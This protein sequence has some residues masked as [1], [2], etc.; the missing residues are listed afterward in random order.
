MERSKPRRRRNRGVERL[1]TLL[2][3]LLS[4]SAVY[5][6][7]LTLVQ[8]QAS[9]GSQ[10]LL[11]GL[12]SLFQPQT[13]GSDSSG[14]NPGQLTA[15]ARPVRI[16]VCDGGNRYAVQYN[17]AQTDKLY[18]SV[19]ILLGEALTS[20]RS[21][22]VV[23]EQVWQ[24][25]LQSPG[26]WFDFLGNIPLETLGAWTGEGSINSAL[27][28]SARQIAVA[29]AEDGVRLYYHNE[30]DGLYYA[31]ATDVVWTGHMDALVS[32]YGG[33]GFTFAFE[34]E[35]GSGYEALDPY[36]LLSP[37]PL[38]LPVYRMSD[39]LSGLDSATVSAIQQALLFQAQGYPVAGG[40]RIREGRETLEL[41]TDG[42]A[43]YHSGEEDASRYTVGDGADPLVLAEATWRLAADTVGRWCGEARLYLQGL[44]TL[45]DGSVQISYG[46]SLNGADVSLPGGVPA[47]S[48]TVR[49]G[50]IS[51][52]SLC[53]RRYE[54]TGQ[55][56]LVMRERQAAAAL[57]ALEAQG[58]ELILAYSAAD[59]DLVQAG[60][61][62]R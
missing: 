26:V 10:G 55:T 61:T 20:A 50:Q 48:F 28:G 7:G 52:Y 58:S 39:P 44:E 57:E 43:A 60:W 24:G 36:V 31:C 51:D 4:L 13:S 62:A 49:D 2:I 12:I 45:E 41:G 3:V 11:G 25:A 54:Q 29:L 23:P 30:S 27:T 33:N 32:G 35:E 8:N 40:I 59:G 9:P 37:D 53:F 47:A 34:Q 15:A 16:A 17:T 6:T 5:L 19:G 22:S 14:G 56:S 42:M 18:D 46:Y 38:Q 1:K 21:P